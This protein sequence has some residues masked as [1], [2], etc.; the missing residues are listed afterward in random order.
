MSHR[1]INYKSYKYIYI[2]KYIP[3]VKCIPIIKL[4]VLERYIISFYYDYA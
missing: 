2:G 1:H 4:Y 3:F